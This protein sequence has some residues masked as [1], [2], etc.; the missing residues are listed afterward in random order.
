MITAGTETDLV[1]SVKDASIIVMK[2]IGRRKSGRRE[3]GWARETETETRSC[4]TC[5]TG[6][7]VKESLLEG[8]YCT[9]YD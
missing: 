8:I 2:S 9:H 5:K 3:E 1:W 6:D 4:I 7:E